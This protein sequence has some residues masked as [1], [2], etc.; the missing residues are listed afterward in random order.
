MRRVAL[1]AVLLLAL[2][3]GTKTARA[4]SHSVALGEPERIQVPNAPDA[5]YYRPRVRGARPILM[6]LHGRGGN[7]AEDCRKWAKV[8]TKF[9]WVVCP[10][11]P[12]DR[13]GGSRAWNNDPG[14]AT[15]IISATV[16]ALKAKYGRRVHTHGN[17]LIGF[18][19]GAFI[20]MQVGLHD[21]VHWNKWLILAANDQYWFGDTAALLKN[22]RRR[23]QRVYLLT[24][25]N[26]EVAEN[27]KRV[28]VML[29]TAKIPVRVR[30]RSGMGHEVPADKM[31]ATYRRPLL[32]LTAK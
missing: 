2:L 32:W 15:R 30:I 5:Y 18:S 28:G 14:T 27:T 24:G 11:G 20:A 16:D 25:E 17:V 22:D 8:G 21:P 10:Q 31:N 19:E 7:P 9:G 3:C 26:D 12:E 4:S 29:K 13:G 23:V 6:Y 1:F